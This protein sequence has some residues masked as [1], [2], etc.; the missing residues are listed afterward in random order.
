MVRWILFR[1]A[2][3]LIGLAG[4]LLVV[5]VV[6][7]TASRIAQSKDRGLNVAPID[8]ELRIACI[9]ES[10]TFGLWPSQ[11]EE[12]LNERTPDRRIRV[13][14]RGIVGIRTD[15]VAR[16]IEQWLDEDQPHLVITMLGINDEGNVLVYP[17][18]GSRGW[19]LEHSKTA[20]LVALL[21]RSAFDIGAPGD[22]ENRGP[23]GDGHLDDETRS[24][25]AQLEGLWPEAIEKY[26]YSELIEILRD[27]IVTDPGTPFYHL[28]YLKGLALH[29]DLPERIDEFLSN[30]VGVDPSD[31]NNEERQREIVSWTERTGDRFAGLKLATSIA[32]WANDPEGERRLIEEA[33]TDDEIAGLAWLRRAD[34]AARRQRRE[35]AREYLLKADEALP[36]DY[37]WSLLLGDISFMLEAY[38]VA[39]MQF[40]RALKL[41]PELPIGHELVWL[42]RLANA[43]EQAGNP[44]RAAGYRAQRDELELG[45]F[46]EFTRFYYQRVIDTVRAREIP[47]I[48]MQYPLLSVEGLRKLLDYRE[49]LTYL[50]NRTNFETALL[51]AS[52]W[53]LFEDNFAGSFGHLSPRG[54]QLVAQNV[55]DALAEVLPELAPP[56]RDPQTVVDESH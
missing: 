6:L 44:A 24:K 53:E 49:D 45:R 9:G 47:V 1:L 46:R 18:D 15:G 17:R 48:V 29:H 11:L 34:F 28:S 4:T 50:E 21:W 22:S 35:E 23:G 56:E 43:Y 51:D 5:E 42:G 19:L 16:E 40:H 41:W 55:A 3:I 32:R 54:N 52:Y 27:L 2:A 38:D 13:I 33:A 25:L 30:V 37:Q 26:R 10:T 36:D 12:I 14:N 8:G 39:A 20:R 7:Q 31:L